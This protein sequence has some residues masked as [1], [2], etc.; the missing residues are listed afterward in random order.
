M[1]FRTLLRT[2]SF[3]ALSLIL[4]G[5][6][7]ARP[8]LAD[9]GHARIVRLSLVQ[10]DVRIAREV[11]GDDLFSDKITWEAAELNLPIRQGYAIATDRGRAEVEFENG[12]MMFLANDAVVEFYDLSLD[13]GERTTRL[14][15]R[16]GTASFYVNPGSGDYFSVTGGDFT[17][18]AEER[19]TFRLDSA[20]D[21]STVNVSKG[22]VSVL[23][24]N[25]TLTVSKGES[26][27]MRVGDENSVAVGRLSGSDNFDRWVSGRIDSLSSATASA[28]QYVSF[29]WPDLVDLW[30]CAN[31]LLIHVGEQEG[32]PAPPRPHVVVGGT[33]AVGVAVDVAGRKVVLVAVIVVQ[34]QADLF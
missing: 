14:V 17:V 13:A 34:G 9:S 5:G 12:T 18:A 30:L 31:R 33:V 24:K 10:G 26:L 2:L 20:D 27:S 3:S 15:L 25:K 22:R 23:R 4:L 11:H 19:A 29:S 1:N 28:Q 7:A 6:F 8:S 21:G 16:R 32:R